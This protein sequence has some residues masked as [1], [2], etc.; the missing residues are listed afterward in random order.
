ALGARAAWLNVNDAQ[1]RRG[2]ELTDALTGEKAQLRA[3]QQAAVRVGPLAA[4]QVKDHRP[5]LYVRNAGQDES[6]ARPQQLDV[7]RQNGPGVGQALEYVVVYQDIDAAGLHAEIC[8]GQRL[9]VG[10]NDSV[11]ALGGQWDYRGVKLHA[12]VTGVRVEALVSLAQRAGP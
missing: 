1:I 8:R 6:G 3:I 2:Q 4:Q 7:A 11:Q 10:G 9:R 5:V 12:E